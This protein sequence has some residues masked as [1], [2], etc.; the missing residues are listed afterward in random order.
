MDLT[1]TP[2]YLAVLEAVRDGQGYGQ[3]IASETG[4]HCRTVYGVL[5]R[6]TAAG[7]LDCELEDAALSILARRPRRRLYRLTVTAL[8][9][10]GWPSRR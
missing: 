10:L 9:E 6:L 2:N 1:T 4:L 5:N 7:W 3:A 8:D